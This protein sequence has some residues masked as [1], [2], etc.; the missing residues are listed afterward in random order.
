M[1][2]YNTSTGTPWETR[3]ASIKSVVVENGATSIGENA[4][5]SCRSLTTVSLPTTLKGVGRSAFNNCDSL[6]SIA[7]PT[8]LTNIGASAFYDCDKLKNVTLPTT[9]TTIGESAFSSCDVLTTIELPG[10]VSTIQD[11]AFSSTNLSTITLP[12]SLTQMGEGVLSECSNLSSVEW[13]GSMTSIPRSTFYCEYYSN[14]NQLTEVTIPEGVTQVGGNAFVSNKNLTTVHLPES[15]ENIQSNAFSNC[16]DLTD[17]YFNGTKAQAEAIQIGTG[18]TYLTSATW[19]F[20]SS[21][22]GGSDSSPSLGDNLT[23][24]LSNSGT[25]TISGSGAMIDLT[26][27]SAPWADKITKI[28]AVTLN[29]GVTSI[30]SNAFNGCES[31]LTLNLPSTVTSIGSN[32]FDACAS[33]TVVNF[34]GTTIQKGQMSIAT[35]NENLTKVDWYCSDDT[36]QGIGATSGTC[37]AKL[38]WALSSD[39]TLTISGTGAMN[40]YTSSSGTPWEARKS[41]IKKVVVNSGATTIGDCAFSGCSNMTAIS[42]PEGIKSIGSNALANCS[43]LKS[44]VLPNGLTSIGADAFYNCDRLTGITLPDTLESIGYEA[45]NECDA[46]ANITLP[47]SLTAINSWAFAFCRNLTTVQLSESLT[48]LPE[49]SFYY[50][51]LS[52]VTIPEGMLAIGSY[53]F[54]GNNTLTTLYLPST[55]ENIASSAFSGCS[56]LADVYYAGTQEDAET[57]LIGTGNTYLSGATWH[58]T[59]G[60]SEGVGATSGTCGAKLTWALSTDGTLTIS[61]TGAMNN[62]TSS[63]GTPWEARKSTIKKVVVNSGATTIGDCAFS[64]CSNMTAISLPEGIKSIGSNALANCSNLKSLVLPNG[65][66]SIGADAFY[67]CDRLTGI[68]LPDTLESIGYEAFNECDALAN[69]TLPNSLTAINS[70]AFAFCRNLTTVQ[71]SES[72][73]RLPEYSFYYCRLSEVTIPEGMLAIGSYGFQGNNTLTTLYLPSTME[74]IA[75]CAFSGCNNLADVYYA[76]TQAQA[77]EILIGTGNTNLTSANWHYLFNAVH[78]WGEVTYEWSTNLKKVTASRTCA[79]HPGEKQK[80]TVAVTSTVAQPATCEGKGFTSYVSAAFVNP[81]FTVQ[82]QTLEDIDPLG[83]DWGEPT[84]TWSDGHTS[85]TATFT[86]QRAGC[87]CGENGTAKIALETDDA[88]VSVDTPATCEA[89]GKTTFTATV[90]FNG[91]TYTNSVEVK[92]DDALNHQW[93]DAVYAWSDDNSSVTA[94]RTCQRQGCA[95]GEHGGA[96]VESETVNTTAQ[97]AKAPTCED[98]GTMTYTATF[99]NMAFAVDPKDVVINPQGHDWG[100]PTWTWSDVHTSATATFTCQR[101]GC[102]FGENGTA[103]IAIETDDNPVSVASPATCEVDGK[104]TYTATVTFNGQTYTNSDEVKTDDALGH[105]YSGNPTWNWNGVE[106]ATATWIC[107]NDSTHTHVV[108]AKIV[109]EVATPATCRSVGAMKFTATVQYNEQLFTDVRIEDIPTEP[110]TWNNGV[111]TTAAGCETAGVMTYTCANCG[112]SK[113]EAIPAAGHAWNSGVITTAAGCE[114]AGVMTYTC[115]NCGGTRT[116]AIPATGHAWNNGVIST[117][118]GCETAGVKTYTCA[119]CG[120]TRIE[121]IPATGHTPIVDPRVEPTYTETGLTEGSHC[122]ICGKVLVAQEVIPVVEPT[123]TPAPTVEPTP[124]PVP[125]VDLSE[126]QITVKNQTYTG[127]ALK[128]TVTVKY[129]AVKLTQN[130]DYTLKYANNKNAGTAKVTVTGMGSYV[131]SADVTFKIAKA[132]IT[133]CTLTEKDQTYTGKALKPAVK[134]TYNKAKLKNGTDYTVTYKNNTN[135]G[136]A[137]VTVTG[138]GNY[139]G[140][141]KLTFNINPKGTAF[142]KMTGAKTSVTLTWKNPKNITGYEI[143]YSLKKDFSGGKTVK[144]KKAKTLTTTIKKLTGGQ[145]YYVRIR[146]FTTVKKKGTFYSVWSKVKTVKTIGAKNNSSV[147]PLEVSMSVGEELDLKELIDGS[148]WESSDEM[149]ATVAADGIVKALAEGEVAISALDTNDEQITVVITVSGENVL[150]LDDVVLLEIDDDLREDIQTD[151]ELELVLG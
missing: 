151:E 108:Q 23:W 100:E 115:A 15:I 150:E 84:W 119:N 57:I 95:C 13:P 8:G 141:K 117:A 32:A 97:Q 54:Q 145:T 31:L 16:S 42:L 106:S 43:N 36:S 34:A 70:W 21:S 59:N 37:G 102:N 7:L 149:V 105:Q 81:A 61:G 111:V 72:L 129:G 69:I 93:G 132:K 3:K 19:H 116:E 122:S 50:C 121:D 120:G 83:H 73:T 135:I 147:A 107:A 80:E 20:E 18:N 66:T 40:N 78:E 103:K 60:D 14:Y 6:V 62:Y 24:T 96:K 110:H 77:E 75:S 1:S 48:R 94:T 49:Y 11:Y 125:E 82:S 133:K 88:P 123:P 2:N 35:G 127:K 47:N 138:K 128:P 46:L 5:Y 65:L 126:C 39:G 45:F 113:T 4:F 101:E 134:V 140:T 130:T 30:G 98:T 10:N 92:T 85:A 12:G 104:T 71:L 68:T 91:Q 79:L 44:L 76:G 74:N 90:T 56:N 52:E 63:S 86:C 87:N 146:A 25:L 142:T 53:G 137:T 124:T 55:I 109:S 136:V 148:A 26:G 131:G 118:A 114:T 33:L 139:T 28:T 22:Q 17:V 41:T 51:R 89:N 99:E 144:I 38:T 67:N 9:L 29:N 64:G 27:G 112:E 143:Q 58:C